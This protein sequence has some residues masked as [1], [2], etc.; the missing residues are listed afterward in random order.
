MKPI[1]SRETVGTF[2][3]VVPAD[4]F[5]ESLFLLLRMFVTVSYPFDRS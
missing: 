4:S 5:R 3:A 1:L 2:I